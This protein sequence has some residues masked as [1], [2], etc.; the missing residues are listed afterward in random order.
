MNN[1]QMRSQHPTPAPTVR[2]E[3]VNDDLRKQALQV[4]R[5]ELEASAWNRLVLLE[6]YGN[7]NLDWLRRIEA[8]AYAC[9]RDNSVEYRLAVN[10]GYQEALSEMLLKL[11]KAAQGQVPQARQP[12]QATSR[13]CNDARKPRTAPM[14]GNNFVETGTW[15]WFSLDTRLIQSISSSKNQATY[16][17]QRKQWPLSRRRPSM[18][19]EICCQAP[20]GPALVGTVQRFFLVA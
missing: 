7:Q 12:T 19:N 10:K 15:Q 6:L 4:L 1:G 5:T 20:R 3:P 17:S 8:E 2:P 13:S 11:K 18:L 16:D 9:H 14:H